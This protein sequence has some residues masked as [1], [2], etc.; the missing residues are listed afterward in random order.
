MDVSFYKYSVHID[1]KNMT[2]EMK[3]IRDQLQQYS[4]SIENNIFF[5]IE[6]DD[7]GPCKLYSC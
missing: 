3:H 6:K 5:D 4:D 1:L 2:K 7:C